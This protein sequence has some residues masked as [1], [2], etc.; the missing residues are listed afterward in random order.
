MNIRRHA[1]RLAGTTFVVGV[2]LLGTPLVTGDSVAQDATSLTNVSVADGSVSIQLDGDVAASIVSSFVL[3]DRVIVDLLDIDLGAVQQS[4]AGAGLVE[5]VEATTYDD[6][7]GSIARVVIHL[8][9]SVGH[10]LDVSG[11]TVT[12]NLG[13][14]ASS[15]SV[16]SSSSGEGVL[17][18]D[19]DRGQR[20]G[21]VSGPSALDSLA[22]A[23]LD[24][25][26]LDD[27]SRI[28]I[29][30]RGGVDYTTSQPENRLVVVDIPGA[31]V[32][33]S[34]TRVL[35]TSEFISPV[36]MVRAYK[37][38]TGA[39]VAVNLRTSAEWN[40][41]AG[42]DGLI[43]VD[44]SVP[45]DMLEDRK[46]ADQGFSSVAPSTPSSSGSDGL[47]GAYTSETL[48]G[49]TGKT[50]D[51]QLA[52]GSG[53]G[54]AD[55]SSV[56]LG[57]AGFGFDSSDATQQW[58]GR[59]INIDL[60]EADI[61]SVFR[62]ISHVS[63]LNIVAGDDVGGSVTVRLENVPWDQAFAAILQAKGY[64][65][66]R[67]GNIVR[68]APIETIKGE[69][70][71]ALE[72]QRAAE[73]LTPLKILVIPLNYADAA[74]AAT[75]VAALLSSRGSVQVD[76]RTN[77][78]IVKETAERL[79]QIRELLRQ[80]DRA[81]PQVLIEARIIEASSSF[82]RSLGIQW[83]GDLNLSAA[84]GSGTGLWF[85]S[86]IGASGGSE[87]TGG[88]GQSQPTFYS[89]GQDNLVVDLPAD[90]SNGSLA[91]SLGSI[92]GVISLDARL[93][94]METEGWGEIISSPRVTTMDN[95]PATIK[96]GA[97][98]PYL[99]TSAGGTSVQFVQAALE[100]VVTPHI[101]SDNKV[102]MQLVV[103]NNRPDFGQ[104]VQGQPAVQIKEAETELLVADG[105]TTVIGGVFST[106]DA[107]S[108]SRVPFFSRIPLVGMLFRSSSR[109]VSR[110]EM[111]VFVTPRIVSEAIDE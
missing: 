96:Q 104:L 68:V 69:Q 110:N 98:I 51:P 63:R 40:V 50:Y 7:Q 64:A 108:T 107:R 24:F 30:T 15:S 75:Q 13:D 6:G 101:T 32:P 87:F 14:S 76:G 60:V 36:R 22:L 111:L 61:H 109:R 34:L 18:S 99:S 67:F 72:T 10:T 47:S 91:V 53:G 43:Y 49:E 17:L 92:P 31:S 73:E 80:L 29:G 21:A 48:I 41:R 12:V 23:S 90:A 100:L 19:D 93:T 103:S 85:P 33:Q 105:D 11:G 9:S 82:T 74:E 79:A 81:T 44:V 55:P 38:R 4:V 86:S 83:G 2:A 102:S 65:A 95:T 70:Q 106:E 42:P 84:T 78:L 3:D 37:T 27:V 8:T 39:R 62:L 28:V 25:E 77:Q 54:A 5:K 88:G 66:Q 35:D 56:A 89:P 1:R 52:F 97:R 94:A 45:A 16:A 26:S 20:V 58:S 46:L 59:R 71:A 57:A